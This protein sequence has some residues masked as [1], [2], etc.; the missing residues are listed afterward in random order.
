MLNGYEATLILPTNPTKDKR[1][2]WRTE[3][4]G[5]FDQADIAMLEKGWCLA[6]FKISNLY[7]SPKAVDMMRSFQNSWWTYNFNEPVIWQIKKAY[8]CYGL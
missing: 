5:A 7:G 1:W 3:F 4:L 8:S 6:Y 2:I